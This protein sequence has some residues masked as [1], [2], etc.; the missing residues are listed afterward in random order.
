MHVDDEKR[1][2]DDIDVT[3]KADKN[4]Q[5]KMYIS[6]RPYSMTFLKRISKVC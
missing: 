3:V 2:E 5:K 4:L 1:S 6:L